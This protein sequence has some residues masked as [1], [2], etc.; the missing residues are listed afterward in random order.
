MFIALLFHSKRFLRS[1][2]CPVGLS[3]SLKLPLILLATALSSLLALP[4]NGEAVPFTFVKIADTSGVITGDPALND[5]GDVVFATGYSTG[6]QHPIVVGD[7]IFVGN[8]GPLR[9][10][11]DTSGPFNGFGIGFFG[12]N[13]SINN[14]GTVGFSAGLKTGGSGI[15]TSD[16][17]TIITIATGSGFSPSLNDQGTAAFHTFSNAPNGGI[18]TGN[19]GPLTRIALGQPSQPPTF[20]TFIDTQKPS[21]NNQGTVAFTATDLQTTITSIFTGS[22][23]PLNTTIDNSGPFQFVSN[24]SINNKGL[25][26]FEGGLKSGLEGIFVTDGTMLRNVADTSGGFGFLYSPDINDADLVAFF[27]TTQQNGFV[28]G[29]GIFTGPDPIADRVIV[30]NDALFGSTVTDLWGFGAKGFLNDAG[31]ITFFAALSNGTQGIF[32]AD[33]VPEP[34]TMLLLGSGLLG[35][36]GYGRKKFFKK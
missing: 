15:F 20:G 1:S 30:T 7:H 36:A 11:A 29:T 19:G 21:I 3:F 12:G 22:G 4:L 31:Q 33:P 35:L 8:G 34:S 14:S 23:G 10:I 17:T 24:P 27:A 2:G 6:G 13:P 5:A 16:G 25:V 18:F 28:T 26:A 9:T 32:R